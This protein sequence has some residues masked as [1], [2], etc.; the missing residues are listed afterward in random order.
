MTPIS[1]LFIYFVNHLLASE[2]WARVRLQAHVGKVACFDLQAFSLRCKVSADGQLE[3]VPADTSEVSGAGGATQPSANVTIRLKLSDLPLIAQHRDKAFSYVKIEGDA[4]FANTIS[5]LSEHLRW[6]VAEDLSKLVGDVAAQRMVT[7]AENMLVQARK[8][9]QAAQ[10]NLAEYF[11]EENPMLVRPAAV[12]A[13]GEQVTQLRDDVERF[14][15][16]LEKLER[17]R[18]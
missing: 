13:F 3:G 18:K 17:A 16:R 14:M 6:E 1:S 8:T 2:P 12:Q 11:L 10:E 7:T 15:K 9:H 4:D 5:Y